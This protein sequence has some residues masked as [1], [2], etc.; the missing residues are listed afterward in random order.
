MRDDQ[1]YDTS[2]RR[3]ALYA[4]DEWQVT[5]RFSAYGGVRWEGIETLAEGATIDAI[6]NR[7]GVTSP[8]V[9]MLWKL[10]GSQKDQV[11]LGLARTYKPPTVAQL[12]PR[13]FFSPINTAVTPDFVGNPRLAPELAWGLDVAYEHY[14]A[15]GGNIGVSLYHRRIRDIIQ[16]EVVLEDGS[17]VSRPANIG[18]GSATG[19]ELDAKGKLSQLWEG[20]PAVDLRAN[21]AYN[22]SRVSYLPGPDNRLGAQVPWNGTVGADY[23][24]STALTLGSSFTARGAGSVRTSLNQVTYRSVDR[25]LETYA[26]WRFSPALQ[27]RFSAQDLLAQTMLNGNRY[28]DAGGLLERN[29]L[30]ARYRRYG[31]LFELK[32]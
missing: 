12:V 28:E 30:A 25:Q 2:V 16:Q 5:E 11:R 8:I 31:V 1:V 3:L 7:S 10:P 27:I 6:R 26:A 29:E 23:K 24:V 14:P 20:A 18:S 4:Q 32:L 17:F 13:R 15:S 21:F 9:N 22:R 19:I